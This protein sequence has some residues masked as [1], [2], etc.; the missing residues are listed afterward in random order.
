[1]GM[2]LLHHVNIYTDIIV[3][4][5]TVVCAHVGCKEYLYSYMYIT[6]QTSVCW[7]KGCRSRKPRRHNLVNV[8]TKQGYTFTISS[9]L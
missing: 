4:A 5:A 1:M 7:F 2:T 9:S 3:D 6:V 8:N